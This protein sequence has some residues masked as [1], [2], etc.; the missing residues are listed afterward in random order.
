MDNTTL[1]ET[2]IIEKGMRSLIDVLGIVD[3][4]RFIAIMNRK[5]QNYDEWR[6][7]YFAKMSREEYE[8]ELF[9][10]TRAQK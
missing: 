3:A 5:K 8:R 7:D 2:T 9:E 4:E 6:K 10:F 1:M